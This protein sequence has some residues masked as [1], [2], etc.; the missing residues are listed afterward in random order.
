MFL[1]QEFCNF[2]LAYLHDFNACGQVN[3]KT[4]REMNFTFENIIKHLKDEP[5]YIK[6]L[7]AVEACRGSLIRAGKD[8]YFENENEA[9]LGRCEKLIEKGKILKTFPSVS[10][11]NYAR[12]TTNLSS[13]SAS[14]S[15]GY[16]QALVT[17]PLQRLKAIECTSA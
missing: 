3:D 1:I 12:I 15:V 14:S 4:I 6:T 16:P 17:I 11:T 7:K 2:R 10:D 5:V 9:T 13:G 8:D